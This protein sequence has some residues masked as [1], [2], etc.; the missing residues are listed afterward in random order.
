ME[1]NLTFSE[2]LKFLKAGKKLV[3]KNWN[4]A[5]M[6]LQVQRPDEYSKMTHP[7][8]YLTIPEG[9]QSNTPEGERRLPWQPAQV[10]L[11]SDDWEI[12]A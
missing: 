3:R 4:A 5:G 11:F 1:N 2:A 9:S 7:Y 12:K 6:Y 10:D 8:L